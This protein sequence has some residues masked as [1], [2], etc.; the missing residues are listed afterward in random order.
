MTC[1]GV[2]DAVKDRVI[3]GQGVVLVPYRKEHV[4]KYHTWMQDPELLFLTGSDPLS[5]EEEYQMQ[6]KWVRDSDKCT[7]IVLRKDVFDE[8]GDEVAAM[9]GDTNI[10][11][12]DASDLTRGEIELMIAEPGCRGKG[13]GKE[14]IN[15]MMDFCRRVIGVKTFVAKIKKTNAVSLHMFSKLGFRVVSESEVFEE[16]T[17]ELTPV[18]T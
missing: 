3:E 11:F 1:I 10:Y 12:S 15:L 14:V 9:I 5:L 6:Q 16:K 4:A 13:Y 8:T 18:A 7:F 2:T 17:L